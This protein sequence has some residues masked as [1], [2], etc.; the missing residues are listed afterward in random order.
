MFR[1]IVSDFEEIVVPEWSNNYEVRP[2]RVV[3]CHHAKLQRG[4]KTLLMQM[5]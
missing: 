2:S 4:V 1:F 5:A 3:G